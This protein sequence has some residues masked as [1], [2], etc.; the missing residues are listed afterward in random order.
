MTPVEL[1]NGRKP[2]KELINLFKGNK[3]HLSDWTTLNVS[4]PPKE[5]PNCGVLKKGVK[6]HFFHGLDKNSPLHVTQVTEEKVGKA[7]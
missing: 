2:R 7:G 4:V 6:D 1:D 3:S 5:I